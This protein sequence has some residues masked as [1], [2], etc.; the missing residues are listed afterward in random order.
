MTEII[1]FPKRKEKLEKDIVHAFEQN[2]YNT[3][4]DLFLEYEKAFELTSTL[5]LLKCETLWEL[6]SYLELKEEA[7]I[8]MSQGFQPYDTLMIYYVKSLFKLKQYRSVVEVIDQVIDEVK[9]HQTRLV[10]LPLRDKA[11]AELNK[12]KDFMQHQLQKFFELNTGEQTK[13]LL[14]L[15]D[16][17]AYQY[18]ETFAHYLN[19]EAL[20]HRI[21]SLIVE[22]LTFARYNQT[23]HIEKFGLKTDVKPSALSGVSHSQF[24]IELVPQLIDWLEKEMPSL[25]SEAYIH[26]N[27]HNIA[28]YPFD[29]R[30]VATMDQWLLAYQVYF[31][32]LTGESSSQNDE[33]S[34]IVEFIK[35]LNT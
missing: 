5:A 11:N 14:N 33:I 17:N 1:P 30:S 20:N 23:V 22:Y 29:I 26:L 8:L 24:K 34:S 13:L 21:V 31:K 27:T 6:E 15:I 18:G 28:L 7:N 19:Y 35:M 25:V 10:F 9:A 32:S 3:V 16:D 4:Y 12:R 2:Q